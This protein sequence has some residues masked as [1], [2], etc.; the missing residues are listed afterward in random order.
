MR[1]IGVLPLA[2]P[3]FDMGLAAE[4]FAAAQATLA[5]LDVD[6]V[7]PAEPLLDADATRAAA[8]S[9]GPVDRLLVLQLTF[10]DADGVVAAARACDA[11]VALWA[12]PEPRTRGRLRLNAL[13][14]INLAAHALARE[15]IGWSWQ[16]RRV[17]DEHAV[18]RLAEL[19]DTP[20]VSTP[21]RL[22]V[23]SVDGPPDAVARARAAADHVRGA[24]VGV[25][26][27]RPD[28]FP[29]CD[30]DSRELAANIGVHVDALALDDFLAAAGAADD[31]DVRAA[32]QRAASSLDDVDAVDQ[33]ALHASMAVYCGLRQAARE[34]GWA[35]AAVRCWPE[36]FTEHGGAACAPL[37]MLTDDG[38]PAACEADVGG[39]L[40]ELVLALLA[41]GS[42]FVADLVDVDVEDDSAVLWHCGLAPL[43]MAD[44][45]TTPRAGVH[46]NR[47]LPLTHE[48]ALKPGR[49]TV[50]RI[51]NTSDG[52]A[53]VIAGA[54][55][56]ARPPSFSGTSGVCRFD[57]PVADVLDTIMSHGL[58]HHYA[59]VYGDVRQELRA[60][61][62]LWDMPLLELA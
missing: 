20:P 56:I 41:D 16:Y 45:S 37:G 52:L 3:T 4:I 9:L 50:A 10:T 1:R 38:I 33:D 22:T 26:G 14:G 62:T 42:A 19:L 57:R 18:T 39:S 60:L 49:I 2:R 28:G 23:P 25:V 32:R 61:A 58:E 35:A 43:S 46:S 47:R 13:C 53:L 24:R 31:A 21:S 7:G 44:P 40:T 54:E 8:A 6:L 29:T 17:E 15:G 30:Y 59:L 55:M 12:F 36:M 11:P 51:A 27:N 34:R 5:G 48:F